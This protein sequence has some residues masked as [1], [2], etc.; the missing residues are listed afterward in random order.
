MRR[1]LRAMSMF[2]ILPYVLVS[3]CSYAQDHPCEPLKPVTGSALQ[4]KIRGTR[5]EGL[6]EAD[7]GSRSLALVSFTFGPLVFP[8]QDGTKLEVT[9]PAQDAAVHVRAVPKPPNIPY[10][11]DATLPAGSSLEWPVNDV[12]LP[13]GLNAKQL[14]VFGWKG[15]IA[16]QVFVPLRVTVAGK[17]SSGNSGLVLAIRASF[18][19]QAL[20]WRLASLTN[21]VCQIPGAWR[22]ATEGPVDAGLP[23][24]ILLPNRVGQ[25]CLDLA[26]Q[27]S[28]SQWVP[29][30]L[31]L[32]IPGHD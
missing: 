26:A 32:D 3:F 27:G 2:Q 7:Y 1:K 14:G 17:A 4:Y 31:R 19:V 12:L 23:V 6:Y 22:D 28:D 15:D 13:E 16:H 25:H 18:D 24:N 5:C 10:E 8:L 11:M 21:Q 29:L 30:S 20:K 9:S